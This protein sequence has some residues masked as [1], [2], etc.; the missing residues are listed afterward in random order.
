MWPGTSTVG[1]DLAPLRAG[2]DV[3]LPSAGYDVVLP[4]L[5]VMLYLLEV[6]ICVSLV[7]HGSCAC[8]WVVRC[9]CLKSA[10]D[11]FQPFALALF[12]SFLPV[13]QARSCLVCPSL[14]NHP[15]DASSLSA[16]ACPLSLRGGDFLVSLLTAVRASPLQF[17]VPTF[18]PSPGISLYSVSSI[19]ITLH[20][21][22]LSI[23]GRKILGTPNPQYFQSR[24][25]FQVIYK[26]KSTWQKIAWKEKA[27]G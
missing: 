16:Q 12:V 14:S 13:P 2:C 5:G 3:V 17:S 26:A 18:L 1:C 23:C 27:A 8:W 19:F 6:L 24:K 4:V 7:T 9:A 25:P 15:W 11:H 22:F 20:W 10:L 21:A